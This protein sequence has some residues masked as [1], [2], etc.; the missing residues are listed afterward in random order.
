M[1]EG[2]EKYIAKLQQFQNEVSGLMNWMQDVDQFLVAEDPAVGDVSTL[3]AQ[4]EQ[5]NA[6]Q[7]DIK[8]LG[9]NKKWEKVVEQA[10][11]KNI[12]LK[13]ALNGSNELAEIMSELSEWVQKLESEIPEDGPIS[14]SSDLLS[15]NKKLQF[16]SNK[17]DKR[18]QEYEKL[19]STFTNI[20]N[21][22]QQNSL[23]SLSEEFLILQ[24]KWENLVMRENDWLDRLE[25]KLKRSPESAADAEEISENLD[26]LENYLRHHPSDRVPKIQKIG[27]YLISNDVLVTPVERDVNLVTRRFE[28]LSRQGRDRQQLLENSIAEAQQ[29]ERH[30]LTVQAWI[31][32]IDTVLQNRLDNDISSQDVPEELTQLEAEFSE[33]EQSIKSLQEDV[34]NYRSRGRIEAAHRLEEQLHLVEEKFSE[35]QEKFIKFQTP[36]NFGNKLNHIGTMLNQVEDGLNSF[37]FSSEDSDSSE[38]QLEKCLQ[39]YKVLSDLKPEL[40]QCIRQGRQIADSK[41]S[42]LKERLEFYKNQYNVLGSRF[43]QNCISCMERCFPNLVFASH[44]SSLSLVGCHFYWFCL[45]TENRALLE[46]AIK[47]ENNLEGEIFHFQEWL[48]AAR[49]DADKTAPEKLKMLVKWKFNYEILSEVRNKKN[50]LDSLQEKLKILMNH[51]KKVLLNCS[52]SI[53]C[54]NKKLIKRIETLKG[55]SKEYS[56][57]FFQSLAEVKNWLQSAAS[58]VYNLRN[59]LINRNILKLN[60]KGLRFVYLLGKNVA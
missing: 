52:M 37:Q 53:Q 41:Q 2:L 1:M 18:Y 5:S 19:S 36:C 60:K 17:V 47:K 50:L 35:L 27:Q 23:K 15:K 13:D 22:S 46:N 39:L 44:R 58:F 59:F 14:N 45:V 28:E 3:E 7:D 31:S 29:C 26:D 55:A 24:S 9:P 16:L 51:L 6:L 12:K 10:N 8:T 32:H 57:D 11:S 25:K 49:M 30:I 20:S 42:D 54:L 43:G 48:H 33:K 40:E 34:E 38:S 56:K 4:L 21:S